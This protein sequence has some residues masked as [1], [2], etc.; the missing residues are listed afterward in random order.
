MSRKAT[1]LC[2]IALT[3]AVLLMVCWSRIIDDNQIE[4]LE[5]RIDQ[6][7]AYHNEGS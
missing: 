3:M 5:Y 6:L 7:E 2:I 1:E 4:A